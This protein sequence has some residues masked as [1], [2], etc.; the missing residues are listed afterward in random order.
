MSGEHGEG[1]HTSRR[2]RKLL[3]RARRAQRAGKAATVLT[4][5][6]HH[7]GPRSVLFVTEPGELAAYAY[8]PQKPQNGP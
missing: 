7:D 1:I 2:P 3:D 4:I 8:F 5:R 6:D